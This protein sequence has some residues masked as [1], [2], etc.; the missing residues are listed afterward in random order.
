MFDCQ[1]RITQAKPSPFL[2]P[3]LSTEPAHGRNEFVAQSLKSDVFAIAL[4]IHDKI[5]MVRKFSGRF[6]KSFPKETLDSVPDYSATDSA[7][8]RQTQTMVIKIVFFAKQYETC[9]V[10]LQASIIDSPKFLTPCN[11]MLSGK[12]LSG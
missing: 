9:R 8:N 7:C 5:E 12:L 3:V 4:R 11:P 2:L 1:A 10:N 6:A